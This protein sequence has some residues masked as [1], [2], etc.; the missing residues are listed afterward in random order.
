M[1]SI[2]Y[3]NHQDDASTV[4]QQIWRFSNILLFFRVAKL[5]MVE[6]TLSVI[7]MFFYR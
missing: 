3:C 6:R 4:T 1:L 5:V 2:K 7:L